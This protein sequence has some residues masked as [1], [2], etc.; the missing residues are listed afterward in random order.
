VMLTVS[1][2]H[3]SFELLLSLAIRQRSLPAS[4]D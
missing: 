4:N 1:T 3:P 2:R